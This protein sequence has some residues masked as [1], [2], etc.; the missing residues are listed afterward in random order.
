MRPG[1]CRGPDISN[2]YTFPPRATGP[3]TTSI[4]MNATTTGTMPTTIR[5]ATPM[6]TSNTTTNTT[7]GTNVRSC[8]VC[9][10]DNGLDCAHKTIMHCN[11]HEP[12]CMNEI[13]S[14]TVKKIS[15]R[16]ATE[17]ECYRDWWLT[18]KQ[19]PNCQG[20]V[21]GTG[22][23][24]YCCETLEGS[25][26]PCNTQAIPTDLKSYAI[27]ES[28]CQI[29]TGIR[30]D[31]F[32]EEICPRSAPFCLNTVSL[33]QHSST[34]LVRKRCA[35]EIECLSDWWNNTRS[36]PECLHANGTLLNIH[37]NLHGEACHYCCFSN[38]TTTPCNI[39]NIPDQSLLLNFTTANIIPESTKSYTTASAYR[40]STV[41][42]V[43]IAPPESTKGS[44][45]TTWHQP[46]TVKSVTIAP[47]EPTKGSITTTGH[48]P[49]TV[50]SVTIA[51]PEPEKA[52]VSQ[53][54]TKTT[55]AASK[56]PTKSNTTTSAYQSSTAKSV[57]IAPPGEPFNCYVCPYGGNYFVPVS[58]ECPDNQHFCLNTIEDKRDGTRVMEKRCA[59]ENECFQ[60]WWQESSD[61]EVC[62]KLYEL[63]DAPSRQD[64]LCHFCCTEDYC[65]Y[66]TT[67]DKS[68]LYDGNGH[69]P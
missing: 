39:N 12:Y 64:L 1:F 53:V 42:S 16:C 43:T 14:T 3:T 40:S 20:N 58:Q 50:N 61:Q 4:T 28:K 38:G 26:T 9:R 23:C 48:Q 22:V 60:K 8:E 18:T 21:T 33:D 67:P 37:A 17:G 57:T 41:N 34:E 52:S 56:E 51:P 2:F 29:G 47:P 11:T 59:T 24:H 65:N 30:T 69:H 7:R 13:T 45:T 27:P 44:I 49:S 36:R 62:K 35:E 15:K 55:L 46:S 10:S 25:E 32:K 31:Q 5:A 6:I 66:F 54:A 68:Q 63:G 19:N